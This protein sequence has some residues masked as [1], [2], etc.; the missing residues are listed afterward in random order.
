MLKLGSAELSL[1]DIEHGIMRPTFNDPRVHYAVNCASVGCPNLGTEAFTGARLDEQLE[2][3]ARAYVNSRRGVALEGKRIVIS[4][5]YVWY[6][7]DF[8]G[9]D[10]GVLEHLRRYAAPA[11]AQRLAELSSIRDHTYDWSLNDISR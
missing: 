4:S 5:I 3:A 2:A 8:G 7:A 1:D 10:Q 11:L 9:S 6:K